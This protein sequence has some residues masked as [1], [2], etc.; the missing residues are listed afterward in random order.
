MTS[1]KSAKTAFAIFTIVLMIAAYISLWPT[2]AAGDSVQNYKGDEVWYV[3]AARNYF[4]HDNI[5][6]HYVT[7]ET[8]WEGDIKHTQ[9]FEGVNVFVKIPD[10]F[11]GDPKWYDWSKFDP[12]VAKIIEQYKLTG[13]HAID[14][15]QINYG[16][17]YL[18]PQDE[19]N[20]FVNALKNVRA[21]K[22]I[23][24]T[25]DT[26][27]NGQ[28]V[29]KTV[30]LFKKGDQIFDVR[31][32]FQYADHWGIEKYYNL[33]HPFLGKMFLIASMYLFGDK[34]TAW[35]IPSLIMYYI[36]MIFV[37][38][39]VVNITKRYFWGGVAMTLVAIDPGLRMLG[40]TGML[41]IY[42]AAFT[43]LTA[44]SLSKKDI[45]AASF[46]TGLAA[47]VKFNG[48][49]VGL[50]IAL[51]VLIK[52]AKTEKGKKLKT[53]I[54][55]SLKYGG[56]ATAAFFIAN[57]P[58]F[59]FLS[60]RE[61]WDGFIASFAWHLSWK[62]AHPFQSPVWNWFFNK[63]PFTIY[64]DPRIMIQTNWFMW[65]LATVLAL[66]GLIVVYKLYKDKY[67][68]EILGGYGIVA[69]YFIMY[70]LGG[71]SQYS[72]Y[73]VQITP[74]MIIIFTVTFAALLDWRRLV[75]AFK[76]TTL[77]KDMKEIVPDGIEVPE[78]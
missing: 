5:T 72:Y 32:G 59:A 46:F 17:Y 25:Y 49:F 39:A 77:E 21:E 68:L 43:A 40:V 22:D 18:V 61:W 15:N 52:V 26:I 58:I 78:E 14:F 10:N 30:T 48:I 54:I 74:F 50:G 9:K 44:Y 69:M 4:Y 75:E 16:R 33:E 29:T 31:P 64:F 11:Q 41:D 24:V 42:V 66:V 53:L 1:E 37:G 71:K 2:Y 56:L 35:R 6:V 7:T 38:L 63:N 3:D 60:L 36:V 20:T 8:W 62:G 23:T 55:D 73:S 12:Y 70:L 51:Y 65:D 27:E 47:A 28:K 19:F 13:I 76:G 57:L 34:P 67:L 45:A